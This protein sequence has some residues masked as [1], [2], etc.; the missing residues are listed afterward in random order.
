MLQDY[1]FGW[2]GDALQRAMDDNGCFSATCGK[3]NSQDISV[4]NKCTLKKTVNEDVDGC[5]LITAYLDARNKM[6]TMRR[7]DEVTGDH[8]ESVRLYK[9]LM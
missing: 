5:K 7:A 6:L 2:K 8:N 3:Q 4:A 9:W 1:V